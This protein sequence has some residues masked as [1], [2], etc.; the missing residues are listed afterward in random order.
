MLQTKDLSE[1]FVNL[2]PKCYKLAGAITRN[3][4]DAEDAAQNALLKAWQ[5]LPEFRGDADLGTWLNR[6]TFNESVQLCRKRSRNFKHGILDL[7]SPT[8]NLDSPTLNLLTRQPI[9][10][11]T[12]NPEQI[13]QAK[14]AAQLLDAAIERL[15]PLYREAIRLFYLEE[16]SAEETAEILGI[17]IGAVKSRLMRGR[18]KLLKLLS[19]HFSGRQSV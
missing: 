6:I 8:L 10:L 3:H 2:G 19:C 1:Q 9:A 4:H 11:D 17:T 15:A 14:Q 13:L 18:E 7:D 5:A 16:K 12:P